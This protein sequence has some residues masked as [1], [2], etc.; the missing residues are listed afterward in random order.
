MRSCA[1]CTCGWFRKRPE[2][3]RSD[4]VDIGAEN[5]HLRPVRRPCR[6]S[7]ERPGRRFPR[8]RP[9]PA[10]PCP[11]RH[12]QDGGL[13]PADADPAFEYRPQARAPDLPRADPG[14][15][16]RTGHPDRR[17]HRRLCRRH[18]HPA[19]PRRRRRLDQC[20]GDAHGT[21]RRR[22]DRHPRPADRPDRA[23]RRR[24]V[25]DPVSGAGRGRPDAGHRLHPRAAP[26]R[27]GCC[28]R[29]ARR[30]CSPPPCPS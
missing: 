7:T 27:Q 8:C 29:N 11:D 23:R 17:E 28:P 21:R 10:G 5:P 25:A 20:A 9:R 4:K 24:P 19:V 6:V 30:C 12:R 26:H 15:D 13:W 22:A 2:P 16:A 1:S 18:P 3:R 14:A